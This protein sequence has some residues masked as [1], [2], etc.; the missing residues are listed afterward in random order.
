MARTLN[1]MEIA[2]LAE[3]LDQ[4]A[5]SRRMNLLPELQADLRIAAFVLRRAVAIG[6][7]ISLRVEGDPI[8]G[9]RITL[10]RFSVPAGIEDPGS[11]MRAIHDLALEARTE[12]SIPFTN[13]IASALNLLPP[14]L[15]GGMLKHV[16]FV[17]TNVPGLT[18]PLYVGGARL[19]RFYSFAPTIGAGVNVS[20]LSYCGVC[21]IGVNTD[22]GAVPDPDV[23]MECLREEFEAILDLG[24]EHGPVVLP[25][26]AAPG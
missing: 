19:E 1:R 12:P 18:T 14:G 9:N 8:G 21:S 23:L 13:A 16:D 20:L 7:P 15:V 3:R 17:A 22:T 6:F 25:A 2:A 10:M 11:R 4:R 5:Q 24:G 26:R